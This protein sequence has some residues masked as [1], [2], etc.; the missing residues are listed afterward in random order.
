MFNLVAV[1]WMASIE[2]QWMMLASHSV[3]PC[4]QLNFKEPATDKRKHCRTGSLSCNA[5]THRRGWYASWLFR[6][7]K[8]RGLL[9]SESSYK[10]AAAGGE[11]SPWNLDTELRSRRW[12]KLESLWFSQTPADPETI[13]SKYICAIATHVVVCLPRESL[14]LN[15]RRNFCTHNRKSKTPGIRRWAW[16]EPGRWVFSCS[17]Q[18]PSGYC[19]SSLSKVEFSLC[20]T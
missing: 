11:R 9:N 16:S 10:P 2:Q 19:L 20:F 18:S 13:A 4:W 14:D 12:L 3:S 7:G 17:K 6:T 15:N 5:A 8:T 1:S